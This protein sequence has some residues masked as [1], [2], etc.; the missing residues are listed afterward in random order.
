MV[1]DLRIEDYTYQLPDERIAKH[2]LEKRDQSKLLYYQNGSINCSLFSELPGHLTTG[3]QLFMN[4]SKV[5]YARLIFFKSTG[6]RIELFCLEASDTDPNSAMGHQQ[7]TRWNCLVGNKKKWKGEV[8]TMTVSSTLELQAKLIEDLNGQ[9]TVELSWGSEDTFAEVLEQAGR[10]PLPPYLNR[11]ANDSDY[12]RYQ[13]V[14]SKKE[15]S[16]A[17]PTAGLHFTPTVLQ[18][19]TSNGVRINELTLHVGAGTFR[20]V[21]T[22]TIGEHDM[23]E[24]YVEVTESTLLSL[25]EALHNNQKIVTV[26]TTSMRSLESLYWLGLRLLKGLPL[27]VKQWDPYTFDTSM[28]K[29]EVLQA[30]LNEVQKSNGSLWFQTG[31]LIAPGYPFQL[32]NGLITNFHQPNSTLLLLVA[33][34]IGKDWERVYQYALKNDFRFLSYGDSSLLWRS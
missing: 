22:D 9:C 18:Q 32:V 7:K 13:T 25:I 21:K 28:D 24:E 23:H 4:N 8:L 3:T 26:G 17:A 19:L 11:D 33:A 6:A 30:L 14:Y 2:P 20:P 15:G 31:I 27:T 16:V 29:V 34:F 10:V 1:K 5:I 12:Q